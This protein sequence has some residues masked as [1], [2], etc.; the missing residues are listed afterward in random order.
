MS[1]SHTEQTDRAGVDEPGAADDFDLEREWAEAR[2]AAG[3]DESAAASDSR[4]RDTDGE[5]LAEISPFVLLY[6]GFML[7]PPATFLGVIIL[8]GRRFELRTAAF[9]LGICGA[10]W[11]IM[12]AATFG[13]A[14]DWSAMGLQVLRTGGNF[15]VGLVLLWFLARKTPVAFGHDRQTVVNTVVFVLLLVAAYSFL[16]QTVLVWLGR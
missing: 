3:L 9:A 7:G 10:A 13:L 2:R 8:L 12:Q 16:P 6:T 11:A 4:A 14:G 1:D 5:G 15:A